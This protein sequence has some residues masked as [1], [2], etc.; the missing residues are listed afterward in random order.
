MIDEVSGPHAN[1]HE[2]KGVN[3]GFSGYDVIN[4]PAFSRLALR[5]EPRP[6]SDCSYRVAI[7]VSP[8]DECCQS[9]QSR[10]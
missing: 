4:A 5:L 7:V 9:H 10:S 3:S 6:Q 2:F 1:G 8:R